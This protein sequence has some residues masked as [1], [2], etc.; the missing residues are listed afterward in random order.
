MRCPALIVIVSFLV[1]CKSSD[2]AEK[3][4]RAMGKKLA[5][6]KT[7]QISTHGT[8]ATPGRF[9]RSQGQLVFA[10][11]NK[12]MI[13]F[14]TETGRMLL[15]SDGIR[16]MTV[17]NEESKIKNTPSQLNSTLLTL[18]LRSGLVGSVWRDENGE[19]PLEER[20]QVSEF[21]LG[22]KDI[23]DRSQAIHFK[24]NV[25]DSPTPVSASL[26]LDELTHLPLKRVSSGADKVTIT[27]TYDVKV[28]AKIDE[29]IFKIRQVDS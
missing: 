15:I 8:F 13:D 23:S 3:L 22:E 4:F 25:R 21:R 2:E 26:W 6:A 12:A 5:D 11:G 10:L 1:G 19:E 7:V 24:M 17:L 29:G 18:F 14:K 20:F 27:D 16:M 9:S 28:N